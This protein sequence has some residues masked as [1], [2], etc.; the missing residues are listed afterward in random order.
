MTDNDNND[1]VTLPSQP[2]VTAIEYD[3]DDPR[4]K[5]N[6][7]AL[8]VRMMPALEGV[9]I[10]EWIEPIPAPA[11]QLPSERRARI[12]S[13]AIPEIQRLAEVYKRSCDTLEA[14]TWNIKAREAQLAGEYVYRD[15]KH[16]KIKIHHVPGDYYV[17][18]SLQN[19]L[20]DV[21]NEHYPDA[22][23]KLL[24]LD[25]KKL[26]AMSRAICV[27]SDVNSLS[28]LLSDA[29][30]LKFVKAVI[31]REKSRLEE[32]R[33]RAAKELHDYK[34]M[35]REQLNSIPSLESFLS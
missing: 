5:A 21:P 12:E 34:Q 6:T 25:R 15:L 23:F 31:K 8:P 19:G 7:S 22:K 29:E 28:E 16:S 13:I 24:E 18:Y 30:T 35:I 17:N 20:F 27:H 14:F 9:E 26:G 4:K 1:D 33:D 2:G 10:P 11:Q 32:L 3:I